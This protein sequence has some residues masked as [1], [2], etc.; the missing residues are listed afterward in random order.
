MN[1]IKINI[2]IYIYIYISNIYKENICIYMFIPTSTYIYIYMCV[3]DRPSCADLHTCT[4]PSHGL[5]SKNTNCRLHRR[6][7]IVACIEGYRFLDQA[8][9]SDH[10]VDICYVS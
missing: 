4:Q 8:W 5:A 7:K 6:I 1:M 3:C 10:T 9:V 2:Y